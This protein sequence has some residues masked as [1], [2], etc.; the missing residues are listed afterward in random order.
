MRTATI[1]T[2]IAA[3][4][5]AAACQ[6]DGYETGDGRYSYLRA[7]L[8]EARTAEAGTITAATTD[9]GERL[10][11]STPL[12]AGWATTPDST[13]RAILYYSRADGTSATVEAHTIAAV[14]VCRPREAATFKNI[15]T[16]PVTFQSVWT[17]ADG[18]YVNLA[19]DL[20]T[21]TADTQDARQTVGI[22]LDSTVTR[23][24]GRTVA[25]LRLYHDQGEVPQYYSS[26]TYLSIP[27][28][29]IKAD[30]AALTVV[31]YKG[32]VTHTVSTAAR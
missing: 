18:R 21:G 5:L 32:T 19:L 9:D 20:K 15:V 1:S 16:D 27:T 2:L 4:C 24:D 12:A 23:T 10:T 22:V 7:D 26:R 25:F 29:N 6:S 30:S 8:V 31:T 28:A 17:G 13:Y 14:P 3:A 11:L